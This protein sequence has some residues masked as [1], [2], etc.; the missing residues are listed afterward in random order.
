MSGHLKCLQ[1]QHTSVGMPSGE[2]KL[3]MAHEIHP[4]VTS[5]LHFLIHWIF[6]LYWQL[7]GGF[8]TA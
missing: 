3:E 6:P 8:V 7:G 1:K 5:T 2:G 4:A